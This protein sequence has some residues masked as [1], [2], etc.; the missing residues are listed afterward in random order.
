VTGTLPAGLHLRIPGL[1]LLLAPLFTLWDGVSML[2]M[3]RLQG[4]L[5]GLAAIYLVWRLIRVIRRRYSQRWWSLIL[6][7][8]GALGL[9]IMFLLGFLVAGALWHRPM[10]SLQGVSPTDKV[11]DFHSHTKASHDVSGTL[12]QG[13]DAEANRR[14]HRRAGFDVVFITDHNT[15]EGLVGRNQEPGTRNQT[16]LPVLCP[17]IE[18]SAWRAHIVLLGDTLPVDRSRYNKSLPALLTL[19][20]ESE[21]EYGSLSLASIPEYRRNHWN[22]LD[23]LIAAGLDGFEIVNAS[24]KANELT[25]R[26]RDTVIS[27][28]RAHNRFV[29]GVSDSH[30]WGATSMV[31]NLVA[32]PREAPASSVCS[33]ILDR[34]RTGFRAVRVIERHRLRPDAWWPLWLTPVGV[35]WET[36]RSM[37][38]ELTLSWIAW[39]WLVSVLLR[40]RSLR[41]NIAGSKSRRSS[42]E[43]S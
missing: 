34:L 15:V 38:W 12:M 39:L 14:W 23:T 30:G 8:L 25:R 9:S 5:L 21:L 43:D 37:G 22:R 35:L 26:D 16:T 42:A 10:L 7:E 33:A 17:G 19:L 13:F 28:A 1:Y 31:W 3:G 32:V 18:V 20:R 6:R 27:L 29:A 40:T 4:F 41:V 24:P 36:W 11:V 2:S